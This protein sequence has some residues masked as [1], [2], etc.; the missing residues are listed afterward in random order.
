MDK[1]KILQ[2]CNAIC[3]NTLMETLDIDFVNVGEDFLTA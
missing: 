3:R 1:E 2:R